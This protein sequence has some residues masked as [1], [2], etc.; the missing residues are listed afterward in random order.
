MVN[1]FFTVFNIMGSYLRMM[2]EEYIRGGKVLA[3]I[4]ATYIAFIYNFSKPKSFLDLR[5][6][7]LCNLVYKIIIKL[8]PNKLKSI[9][10]EKLF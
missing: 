5:P 4:N 2:V 10:V 3:D 7:S 1:L 6:F 9:L 8:I